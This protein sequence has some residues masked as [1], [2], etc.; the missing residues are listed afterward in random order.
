[1]KPYHYPENIEEA[2]E[3]A[4]RYVKEKMEKQQGSETV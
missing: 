4:L 2:F 3:E 1:V